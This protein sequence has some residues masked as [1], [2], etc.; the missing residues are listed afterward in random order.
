MIQNYYKKIIKYDLLNKFNY[1]NVSQIPKIKKIILNFDCR[2]FDIKKLAITILTLEL[3]SM[4]KVSVTKSKKAS[5]NLKIRRGHPVGCKVILTKKKLE[6]FL[7]K[8]LNKIFPELKNFKGLI[9][10]NT[11]INSFSFS[12]KDL[13]NF[14]ELNSNFY[15]FTNL[16]TLN[17]TIVFDDI[18]TTK[19]L[20]F[21]INSLKIPLIKH[22]KAI[23]T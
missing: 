10:K 6:S 19:E 18:Y 3:I 9:Q 5:I 12:I 22:T 13:I 15:L 7:L 17:I 14:N 11:N 1:K 2:S 16:P 20:D 21:F 4:E 23:I 8:L